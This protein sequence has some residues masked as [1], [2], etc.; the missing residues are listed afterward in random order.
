MS[1]RLSSGNNSGEDVNSEWNFEEYAEEFRGK[2]SER[3]R[4]DVEYWA[5]EY[6]G[7][8]R[9]FTQH[10]VTGKADFER[11]E[12]D[13]AEAYGKML[14]AEYSS[15]FQD[16]Y[17]RDNTEKIAR[18]DPRESIEAES[19]YYYDERNKAL[20]EA[21]QSNPDDTQR[22]KELELVYG[23]H[24]LVAK[25]IEASADSELRRTDV[26][27]YQRNRQSAHN[28]LIDRLNALN[29][30]AERYKVKRFTFRDFKTNNFEYD[31]RKDPYGETDARY[32]YDRTCVEGW[33]KRAFSRDFEQA[34]RERNMTE[35][36]DSLVAMFH[37]K[38]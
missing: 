25:H 18:I 35:R 28:N 9:Q 33:A 38:D 32:D 23:L 21:I 7:I 5:G 8:E 29:G 24:M 37:S 6:V 31:R 1:E 11:W 2:E 34:A 20:I 3:A 13:A 12:A 19:G 15:G 16:I 17:E 22:E 14:D 27:T 4:E 10:K 36:T 30:L 26:E